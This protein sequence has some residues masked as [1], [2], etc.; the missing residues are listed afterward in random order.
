MYGHI[1]KVLIVDLSAG[2]YE[3]Q[4]LN[5]EW[6]RD[7]LSGPAL[8]ARYLYEL[9]PAHTPALAPESVV[10]FVAG[11]MNGTK[12][13]M[14]GRYTVVSK[15]P[16]TGGFNDANAGGNFGPYLK[17]SGFDAVF[18]RG[19]SEKPAYIFIDDGKVEIRDASALWGKTTLDT[20]AAIK[21][22][23]GDDFCAA[24]I[25]PA[26]ERLSYMAAVMNDG[27]RAA[28][29]GGTGA[30]MGSKRLKALVCR[31]SHTVSVKAP[32]E[33]IEINRSWQE[34]AKGRAAQT[35][36]PWSSHGTASN[37]E[38]CVAMS[39]AG[40]RNWGGLPEELDYET[41]IRPLTGAA[42]D[43]AYNAK[44]YA[45]NSCQ[46]GCG[47][48]LHIK[49]G[50]YD[51]ESARPEYETLGAFGSMLLNGDADT[52]NI[53]N[54]YCNE[55]GYD[56][57]S[58]GGTLA[59]LMECYENRLF[60]LEELDGIDLKWGNAD[61]IV[62]MT[63][64]ICEYK[65]IGVSLG[66]ASA[67][68]A[69][70]L[71]RGA[72]YLCVAGDIEIPHH[73]G[74][75]NPAMART[76]QYDPTPGRHVKGGRGAGFGFGPPE[77]KYIYE[78]TGEADKAGVINAEFDNMSGFC[79]FAFLMHR[80]AKFKYLDAVSGHQYTREEIDNLGLRSFAIRSAF[81]LREGKRRKDYTI[82]DRNVGKPPLSG[83]PLKGITVDN[84]KLGDNF[85]E[86][87]GWD[88]GTG[89]PTLEFLEK[90]GGLEAVIRDLYPDKLKGGK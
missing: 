29:R 59:W 90:V 53:C 77:V 11:Y 67:K 56:T 34:F 39:D 46:I 55:Y 74:R 62:R 72:E 63:K 69:E 6:A 66:C 37:Y 12:S 70:T 17:R 42:M 73:C 85:F 64:Q 61:A 10:G 41:Q 54:Y 65:G 60:T 16:F 58:M 45:C 22:E 82:S 87:M 33:I 15:S 20:E 36:Q 38:S 30:V 14:G 52:V 19:V 88:V 44:K 83:G 86:A 5:P 43:A 68:A 28:G 76:F 25:G 71:G 4:E 78:D 3:I 27:H 50:N 80:T 23:V 51:F 57:I 32:E 47:A 48:I 24:L 1:G 26:G 7:F 35:I 13:F 2:T 40:I 31:G 81:N 84:E 89:V 75:N 21:A 49:N 79:H 18:V 9:M 8:G